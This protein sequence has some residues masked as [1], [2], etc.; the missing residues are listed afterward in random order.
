MALL[1]NGM[2]GHFRLMKIMLTK[3]HQKKQ[4]K[5]SLQKESGKNYIERPLQNLLTS[6]FCPLGL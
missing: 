2:S 4:K 1:S 3:L 6:Q 5:T